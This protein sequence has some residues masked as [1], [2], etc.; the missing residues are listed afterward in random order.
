MA[1][2]NDERFARID[3]RFDRIEERFA[4]GDERLTKLEVKSAVDHERHENILKRLDRI[5][6]H[7]SKLVWLIITAINGAFMT[8]LI[9]GGFHVG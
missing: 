5:V 7:I 8:F 1:A 2:P 3:E 9:R 6:G 4:R